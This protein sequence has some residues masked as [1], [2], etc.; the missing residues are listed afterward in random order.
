MHDIGKN[1]VGALLEGG[2]FEVIDL[3]LDVPPERFV[4]AVRD[5]RPQILGFSALL[6]TTMPGMK[7]SLEALRAAGVRDE[8]KVMIGG[9][10]VTEAY[11]QAIG[12]DGYADNAASAVDLARRLIGVASRQ[13]AEDEVAR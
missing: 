5:S 7:T 2:G 1:L 4:A 6:T 11:S 12:A 8:V 10:P 13:R 9:A 3:G